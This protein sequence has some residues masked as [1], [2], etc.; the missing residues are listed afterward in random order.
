[1]KIYDATEIDTAWQA[2]QDKDKYHIY[3]SS[4]WV[5]DLPWKTLMYEGKYTHVRT[6]QG[7]FVMSKWGPS[8]EPIKEDEPC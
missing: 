7:L 6:C 2:A 3:H 5:D 4:V 1:M 8:G